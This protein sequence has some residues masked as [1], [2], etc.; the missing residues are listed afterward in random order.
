MVKAG[1]IPDQ[2]DDLEEV[3]E[4]QEEENSVAPPPKEFVATLPRRKKTT[5]QNPLL[6]FTEIAIPHPVPI[7]EKS[8]EHEVVTQE[9]AT[10]E[11]GEAT[12]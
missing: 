4:S 11:K 1:Y 7:H 2:D 6:S 3:E 9:P 5:T 10:E 8:E 12:T